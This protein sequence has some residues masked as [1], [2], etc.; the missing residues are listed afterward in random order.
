MFFFFPSYKISD[1][2]NKKGNK[3]QNLHLI[4]QKGK[5]KMY[6]ICKKGTVTTSYY[7]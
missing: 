2:I 7:V 5:K 4:A 3:H 1:L 6:Y